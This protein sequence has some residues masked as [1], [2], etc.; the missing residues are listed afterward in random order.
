V[1]EF[2]PRQPREARFDAFAEHLLCLAQHI[3]IVAGGRPAR[4]HRQR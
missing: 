3:A 2:Q 1:L 4:M